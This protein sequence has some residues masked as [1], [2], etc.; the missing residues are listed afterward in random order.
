MP[1]R[2]YLLCL[3]ARRDEFCTFSSF[4]FALPMRPLADAISGTSAPVF[5][6]AASA[7][8][9]KEPVGIHRW[10]AVLAGLA[11]V[12]FIVRPGG[13]IP[14]EGASP[15]LFSTSCSPPAC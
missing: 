14:W 4:I 9:L 13:Q 6:T 12:L 11:A 1:V 10:G 5:I 8:V 2:L 7:F 15:L 3:I